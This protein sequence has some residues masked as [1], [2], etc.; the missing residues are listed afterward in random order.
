VKRLHLLLTIF[1]AGLLT[2]LAVPGQAGAQ[3]VVAGCPA[4]IQL[5]SPADNATL[6][7]PVKLR[8][9]NSSG[10]KIAQAFFTLNG[11]YLADPIRQAGQD[12]Q[13][14]VNSAQY[15][16]GLHTLASVATV[17]NPGGSVFTC[18]TNTVTVK[19][20]NKAAAV[21]TGE[22]LLCPNI[23]SWTGPANVNADVLATAR[24][25]NCQ[26]GADV[27]AVTTFDWQTS[28]GSLPFFNQNRAVFSSGPN[29][30]DGLITIN[31]VGP[32]NTRAKLPIKITVVAGQKAKGYPFAAVPA[33]GVTIGQA[34]SADESP[35]GDPAFAACLASKIGTA[36][37]Q[38]AAA[39]KR[40]D[41]SALGSAIDCFAV[42]NFVIPSNLAPVD[43][44]KVS[45]LPADKRVFKIKTVD[46]VLG[47]AKKAVELSGT[48][49]P[50][51][52]VLVY[53]YSEPLVGVTKADSTG[54]W[55]YA[56]QDP[57][58]FGPHKAYIA[59]PGAG[60]SFVRSNVL[61]FKV[62]TTVAGKQNPQGLGFAVLK[63]NKT[64]WWA[65]MAAAAAGSAAFLCLAVFLARKPRRRSDPE[66]IEQ[67]VAP[68]AV[69]AG[70]ES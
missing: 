48:A 68:L 2:A 14:S 32:N 38:Q 41:L 47:T 43:P 15:S 65:V 35:T 21:P 64:L 3:A 44:G 53:V 31:A 52:L 4:G 1:I 67:P 28:L 5:D 24:Y 20:S 27:T 23:P 59:G 51:Q 7:G 61:Q 55:S 8:L 37:R 54:K 45:D 10:Q 17:D 56:V 26:T 19:F 29:T 34:S 33:G 39:G 30:G 63:T 13:T 66:A 40:L 36:T 25:G 70:I 9:A 12:W 60:G 42:H 6:S 58:P 46:S 50:G 57:L 16:N 22:L 69:T 11:Q 62:L 49:S 18:I